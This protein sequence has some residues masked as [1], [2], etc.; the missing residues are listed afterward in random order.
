[1]LLRHRVIDSR[2]LEKN[3]PTESSWKRRSKK[4][5]RVPVFV[6]KSSWCNMCF[7]VRGMSSRHLIFIQFCVWLG[8]F[9]ECWWLKVVWYAPDFFLS[10]C[11]VLV[12]PIA[13]L[14]ITKS[15]S[16]II[17][18]GTLSHKTRNWPIW[19]APDGYVIN[20]GPSL[21]L[22]SG[23]LACT[24]SLRTNASSSVLGLHFLASMSQWSW[25]DEDCPPPPPLSIAPRVAVHQKMMKFLSEKFKNCQKMPAQFFLSSPQIWNAWLLVA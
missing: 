3:P 24:L 7:Q 23:K 10:N 8:L 6:R 17:C 22:C 14:G 9:V 20:E 13:A 11:W 5:L 2:W 25:C 18:R 21:R 12:C 16:K 19:Q 4:K 1:M 15:P